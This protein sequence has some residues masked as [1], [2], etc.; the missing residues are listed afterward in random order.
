LSGCSTLRF[1][2]AARFTFLRSSLLN[3]AVLA[4]DELKS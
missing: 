3:F 1:L 4:M 2:R